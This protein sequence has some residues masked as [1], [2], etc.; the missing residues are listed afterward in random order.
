MSFCLTALIKRYW[1]QIWFMFGL[2]FLMAIPLLVTFSRQPESEARVSELAVPLVE[3]SEGNFEPLQEHVL[4][5]LSM[6]HAAG[7]DEWLYNIPD[8]PV[9]GP[10]GA[11]FFWSGVL[12]A[13]LYALLPVYKWLFR[14]HSN[15]LDQRR[16]QTGN[17]SVFSLCLD[18]VVGRHFTGFHQRA[19]GQS[20][21]HDPGPTGRLSYRLLARLVAEPD[22]L[23]GSRLAGHGRCRPFPGHPSPCA[24][25]PT[26]SSNGRSGA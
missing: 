16:D 22:Q 19:A 2:A 20:G 24:I 5:T 23:Q 21:P 7:D 8:R 11:L 18:L 3:A 12:I 9:F 17:K 6:F 14:R 26:I 4:T 13:L 10:V 1:K 25:F 15:A